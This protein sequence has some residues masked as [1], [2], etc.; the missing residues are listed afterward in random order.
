VTRVAVPL[1]LHAGQ[2]GKAWRIK[3]CSFETKAFANLA[4]P[5]RARCQR[6]A[7]RSMG[8]VNPFSRVALNTRGREKAI[9]YQS[10]NRSASCGWSCE[11]V[12]GTSKVRSM[13]LTVIVG[14]KDSRVRVLR[15]FCTVVGCALESPCGPLL[16]FEFDDFRR[17]GLDLIREHFVEHRSK[18]LSEERVVSVFSTR[19]EKRTL[20][21]QR[22][23]SIVE[24]RDGSIRLIPI[25]VKKCSLLGL[26]NLSQEADQVVPPGASESDF[27]QAFDRALAS[28]VYL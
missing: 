27:W 16:Q 22:A 19:A 8:I 2:R 7:S 20:V 13:S 10:A 1:A 5:N 14:K 9:S 23:V 26:V 25:E 21:G 28:S 4:R 11:Q 6:K 15:W 24:E 17:V 12:D 18:R 3:K